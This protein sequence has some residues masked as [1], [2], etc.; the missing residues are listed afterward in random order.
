MRH[1]AIVGA[2]VTGVTTAFV[3][4]RL[5]Y[6]ITVFDKNR[7]PAMETSFA[8]GGQLSA[9]NAEVW[10]SLRTVLRGLRWI[11]RKDAPL[12]VN[13]WPSWHKYSWLAEFLGSSRN[14]EE[15][16][17]QTAKLAIRSREYTSKFAAEAGI[18]FDCSNS[19]ILHFYQSKSELKHAKKVSKLLAMAGL[20]RQLLTPSEV[21]ELEPNLKSKVIGGYYT[22]DD[23]TGDAHKFSTSLANT[24]IQKGVNFKLQS[25]VSDINQDG[26]KIDLNVVDIE[27]VNNREEFDAVVVAAGVESRAI[28]QALGD[29]INIYPV[30]GY[31][32][33]LHLMDPTSQSKAPRLSLLDDEAKIVTSRLGVDRFRIAGT[34]EING[35][36]LDIR[37]D[38]IKPLLQWAETNF[39][40]VRTELFTPWAGLRPMTPSMMPRIGPGKNSRVFYNTGHGHLG[41]TLSCISA[42]IIGDII[43]LHID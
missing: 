25:Y 15:N 23:F 2:G 9:S 41:W 32:I 38:R 10:S 3:L 5:G 16:T 6:Q 22:P 30:K 4:S 29:R 8:N 35:T 39:P 26:Q 17:I 28:A 33:T 18:E 14:Y 42:Q 21:Y 34:A 7:Y 13:L 20:E 40:D 31:S 24:C 27:G 43:H 36:N 37:A 1:I 19:G 12:L 11:F